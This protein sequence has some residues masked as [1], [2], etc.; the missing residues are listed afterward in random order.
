MGPIDRPHLERLRSALQP[1]V[2]RIILYGDGGGQKLQRRELPQGGLLGAVAAVLAD[3]AE[4][5]AIVLAADLMHPSA[6]LLRY[7]IQVRGG[8]EAIVPERRDGR[9]QPLLALYH[10]RCSRRA[11]GLVAAGQQ[12][13]DAL[14]EIV[15]V[16]RVTADEVAKFGDPGSLLARAS[17]A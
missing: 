8:H 15:D 12:A 6:E 2:E 3:A 17:E 5:H 14:L 16:R 9:L 1:H 4:D 13:L 7:M 11:E 10:A